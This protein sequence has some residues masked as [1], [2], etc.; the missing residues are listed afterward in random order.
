MEPI[1]AC[2][3]QVEAA[4]RMQLSDIAAACQVLLRG[5]GEKQKKYLSLIYRAV[6]CCSHAIYEQEL[7]RR[8]DDE[9]ELRADFDHVD[10]VDWCRET[11]ERAAE[12]LRDAQVQLSFSCR[13]KALVTMADRELLDMLLY[14]LISNAVKA[15][16]EGCQVSVS[17]ERRGGNALL[18][19]AD[20][21]GGFSDQSLERLLSSQPL[22]PDLTPGAGAGLGLRLCRAIVETHGGLMM[23]ESAPGEGARCAATLPI[24]EGRC[25]AGLGDPSRMRVSRGLDRALT[26]LSDVLPPESFRG[27]R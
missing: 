26:V 17:L 11:V 23:L 10:L 13:E 3:E 4:M 1:L 12:L 15:A 18:T 22:L 8:L 25:S 16:G 27:E 20:Q 5:A 9:D 24:R 6:F 21:G 7:A 2:P 14:S 19:V